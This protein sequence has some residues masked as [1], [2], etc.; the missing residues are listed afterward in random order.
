M[1]PGHYEEHID[2][3][4]K[5]NICRSC[6][7]P[8]HISIG[9]RR[10]GKY[11]RHIRKI[12][13]L[14]QSGRPTHY[15]IVPPNRWVEQYC[16][17]LELYSITVGNIIIGIPSNKGDL[18]RDVVSLLPQLMDITGMPSLEIQKRKIS[19]SIQIYKSTDGKIIK[20]PRYVLNL[21]KE[22]VE[23]GGLNHL[24]LIGYEVWFGLPNEDYLTKVTALLQTSG[25]LVSAD[26]NN[27][28]AGKVAPVNSPLMI[29]G[30]APDRVN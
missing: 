28:T 5:M 22:F 1:L 14:K 7:T 13:A 26:P 25:L 2:P 19:T 15:T 6:H 9:N 29:P 30:I 27:A 12:N 11:P 24:L 20:Y 8:I 16:P 17:N 3:P 23:E 10:S 18:L 21:P 4:R